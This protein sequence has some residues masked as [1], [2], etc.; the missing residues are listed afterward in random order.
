MNSNTPSYSNFNTN[1]N[2]N[3]IYQ[4]YKGILPNTNNLLN[5]NKKPK[6]INLNLK[7]FQKK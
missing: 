6:N 7:K 4:F 2:I 1:N 5:K 3:S